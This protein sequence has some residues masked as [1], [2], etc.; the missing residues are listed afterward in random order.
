MLPPLHRPDLVLFVDAVTVAR[1]G[2]QWKFTV[3]VTDVNGCWDE[4]RVMT[5]EALIA[6]GPPARMTAADLD[7]LARSLDRDP[8]TLAWCRERRLLEGVVADDVEC[9]ARGTGWLTT[10]L[11]VAAWKV[12]AQLVEHGA[13]L[14]APANTVWSAAGFTLAALDDSDGAVAV[15][16]RLL[17]V[18]RLKPSGALLR[19]ARAPRIARALLDVGARPNAFDATGGDG[20]LDPQLWEATPLSV[21]V[22]SSRFDVA[23]VLLAGGASFEASDAQGRTPLWLA[24]RWGNEAP[25]RWLLDRGAR[26]TP[27]VEALARA[28][29]NDPGSKVLLAGL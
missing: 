26:V 10:A 6:N 20:L 4:D 18:R 17:Q 24:V 2:A 25:V 8:A 15:L 5:A 28:R 14:E 11:G 1:D 9:G 21:A 22:V 3:R 7:A 13:R 12:A 27:K 29:P 23:E 19:H 16:Q